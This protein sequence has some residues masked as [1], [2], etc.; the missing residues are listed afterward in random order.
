VFNIF[1]RSSSL[2]LLLSFSLLSYAD[3][4]IIYRSPSSPL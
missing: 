4:L 3:M 2:R 1:R